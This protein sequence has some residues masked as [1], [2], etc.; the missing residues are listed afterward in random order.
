MGD[1]YGMQPIDG[2]TIDSASNPYGTRTF[3]GNNGCW[4]GSCGVVVEL[5]PSETGWTEKVIYAFQADKNG[6]THLIE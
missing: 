6:E 1:G 5:V 3:G 2:V 4:E